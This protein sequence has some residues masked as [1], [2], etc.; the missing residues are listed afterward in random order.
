[1]T[2]GPGHLRGS[3]RLLAPDLSDLPPVLLLPRFHGSAA[4]H[5]SGLRTTLIASLRRTLGA[6]GLVEF[7]EIDGAIS[8]PHAGLYWND[9]YGL[10]A[11]VVQVSLFRDTLDLALGGCHGLRLRRAVAGPGLLGGRLP[12]CGEVGVV[13]RRI[14]R[15][16][17]PAGRRPVVPG[18]R[19]VHAHLATV[20]VPDRVGP[21][22]RGFLGRAADFEIEPSAAA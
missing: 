20:G 21:L 14:G 15:G 16:A 10:P 3:L 17:G 4:A 19:V 5:W 11:L 13:P 1:M 18:V 8:W 7:Q 6:D 2:E 9:L 22:S 12:A